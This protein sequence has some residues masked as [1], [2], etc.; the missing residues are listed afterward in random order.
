MVKC[1]FPPDFSIPQKYF[2]VDTNNSLWDVFFSVRLKLFK[3]QRICYQ[4][5]PQADLLFQRLD[6]DV[7]RFDVFV[8]LPDFIPHISGIIASLLWSDVALD[9]REGILFS[10]KKKKVD[11]ILTVV[12]IYSCWSFSLRCTEDLPACVWLENVIF[13]N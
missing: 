3:P 9:M 10:R 6:E 5:F 1:F 12:M 11:N 2:L 8:L 7:F 13:I 4:F